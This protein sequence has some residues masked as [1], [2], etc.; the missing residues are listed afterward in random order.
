MQNSLKTINLFSGVGGIEAGM[1]KAGFS[2]LIG[3][4]ID[5]VVG[6]TY[7]LNHPTPL[8]VDDVANVTAVKILEALGIH[9]GSSW[10]VDDIQ[11]QILTG[12]F[13]CQPFS[14]A[15]HRKGFEDERGNVF[16][17]IL[18]L[19]QELK[20]EVVFLENVKNLKQHDAGRTFEIII[21]ALE[22]K[23]PAPNG[24]R[25]EKP[26]KVKSAILNAKD[27]GVPQNRERIYILAFRDEAVAERFEFPTGHHRASGKEWG[28]HIQVH[29][30]Y[31]YTSERPF[32]NQLKTEIDEAGVF[33][34][35]RRQYV[36]KNK[37]DLCP[38]L[39]ANMGLG[40]HNVP[41]ILSSQ[42]IRK[43]TPKECFE[44]MGMPDIMLPEAQPDSKLYKQAG[45]SVVVPVIEAI[46]R[47]L[48]SSLFNNLEHST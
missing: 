22:G 5:S 26:Y 10:A 13:P 20:P 32:Y 28:S 43:L 47:N 29:E 11:G 12:G 18:R 8:V 42:G 40:G 21:Q 4:E 1:E 37:S 31:I 41:L 35:W 9:S 19:V 38:T 24:M 36:R 23:I 15:G 46:A 25:L 30:K 6:Q 48:S 45:N 14:V 39:T 16:W 7:S 2:T 17:D 44:L 3:N 34:Q 33:Y 27:F